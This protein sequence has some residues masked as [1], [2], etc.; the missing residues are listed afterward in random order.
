[1]RLVYSQAYTTFSNPFAK[2]EQ[3]RIQVLLKI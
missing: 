3:G 1:M 2:L